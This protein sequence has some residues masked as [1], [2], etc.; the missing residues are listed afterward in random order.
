MNKKVLIVGLLYSVCYI[1]YKLILFLNHLSFEK[2]W[3]NFAHIISVLAL[4]PFFV[5]SIYWIKSK[6]YNGT[7]SGKDAARMA[8]TT[9]AVALI[10][11]A[12]YNYAEF[13]VSLPQQIEYYKSETHYKTMLELQA[14]NAS[15]FKV[16][17]IPT[18]IDEQI[19]SLSAIKATTGKLF[20]M[21][22]LGMSG[23][24]ICALIMKGGK[25]TVI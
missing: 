15:K 19:A 5:I 8:L 18:I 11:T 23:A 7:I 13:K 14:K 20:S 24:F 22:I 9:F 16:E 1:I 12:I 21:L 17:Q 2:F 10:L 6:D 25:K 4:I 3:F